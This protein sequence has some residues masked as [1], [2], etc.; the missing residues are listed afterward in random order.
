MTRAARVLWVLAAVLLA[1]AGGSRADRDQLDAFLIQGQWELV[2][3]HDDGQARATDHNRI[4]VGAT[5]WQAEGNAFQYVLY[6]RR[7]PKQVDWILDGQVWRGIYE[8]TSKELR[9]CVAPPGRPRP[10]EFETVLGDQRSLH[11]RKRVA[12]P[13]SKEGQ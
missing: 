4:V 6:P 10:A 3:A 7:R 5:R 1:G 11:V 9:L 12:P 13:S 2:S 8:V